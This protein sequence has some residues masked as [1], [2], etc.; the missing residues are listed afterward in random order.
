MPEAT[1]IGF[2]YVLPS[3]EHARLVMAWRNDP[4][5]LQWS[6]NHRPKEW[7]VFL[8]EFKADYFNFIPPL[9][10]LHEGQRVAFLRFRPVADPLAPTRHCCD[11]SINVA[12]EFRGRGLGSAILQAI[13]PWLAREGYDDIYAEVFKDNLASLKTFERAGYKRLADC[14][15]LLE[16]NAETVTI[17]RFLADL[18]HPS[19]GDIKAKVFI[20]AEAGS[21]WRMGSRTRDL[22]MA[23]TLI[24]LAAEA[25]ADAVKF[26][27]FRAKTIYVANA[28]SS[29]YLADAGIDDTM[30]SL[31]ADL[32][33]PYE[34]LQELDALC[35]RAAIELMVT[36]FSS[37]DF[38]AV[39]P[40]VRRHKIA[41]YEIGHIHL[42]RLA[43]Q[44]Q[45]PT[46]IS[47][48]AATEEEIAWAVTAYR[49]FG[50]KELTLMQCTACYPAPP[51]SMNLRA[52]SWL[53]KRF[54]T[55]VGLSDHSQH[56]IAAPVAAVAL[57]AS[58]IEK[59][60]TLD[61]RLPGPDHAF[62]LTPS[63]LKAMVAAIREAEQMRGAPFKVIADEEQELR[64]FARRGIQASKAI[65]HGDLLQEGVN[66]DLLRPGQRPL[67]LHAKFLAEIEGQRAR[68]AIPLGD[69]IQRGDY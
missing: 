14:S 32:E 46:I 37:T 29:V 43:A 23:K 48:G 3:E 21:N 57:G 13:K 4:I 27:C 39:D 12:P 51:G 10:A 64:A 7:P 41:S 11:I 53:H 56:P 38:A 9:F 63:E 24:D 69:G 45:K 66:I 44:S 42:L 28:G 61:K 54:Q 8:L 68:R 2:E 58:T 35:C 49:Q 47:T 26:Q 20:I 22:A 50:G 62:A 16:N 25:G 17:C 15:K 40:F 67:G 65:G 19:D 31:F 30:E 36:P 59:H 18:T 1:A 6:Y 52:I 5:T 60:F 34:M 55:P 33:M